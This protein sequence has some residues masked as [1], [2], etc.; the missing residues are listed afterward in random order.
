[1]NMQKTLCIPF[2]KFHALGNDFIVSGS[3][4]AQCGAQ[5]EPQRLNAPLTTNHLRKLASTICE[6]HTGLGADGFLLVEARRGPDCDAAVRFFNADGSEAEM[7]GNG[8]RCVGAVLMDS[9]GYKT[10]L[11]LSTL[12]GIRVLETA[13]HQGLLWEFRVRMGN[14]SLEPQSI[15]FAATGV[16]APVV[17]Y[18]LATRHGKHQVTVTSM[19]NPHCSIFVES[20]DR[21]DWRAIG[22]E[23]EVHPLFPN[24]TNVEF[25]RVVSPR[26]IQVRFWE[27]GVGVTASS[28]TG[29]SAAAV[30]S[31]L[32]GFT[33]RKVRVKTVAGDLDVAWPEGGELTLTGPAVKIAEGT[34]YHTRSS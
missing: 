1:M 28:G 33:R 31:I 6:R 22:H 10:P 17:G 5:I 3:A 30:A 19:G 14:P 4:I 26:Q 2:H 9:G 27:R 21:I 25:V 12:A 7:S 20:F 15:P 11:R 32:N 34:Y 16:S 13:K 8:I 24:R 23:I 29:S 18:R